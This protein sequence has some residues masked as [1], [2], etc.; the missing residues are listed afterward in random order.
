MCRLARSHE[1][2][3]RQRRGAG[4]GRDRQR[5][6]EGIGARNIAEDSFR[7]R[8]DHAQRDQKQDHA[9]GNRQRRFRDVHQD[10]KSVPTEHERKQHHIGDQAFAEDDPDAVRCRRRGERRSDQ[11]HV[12]ERVDDE[13]QQDRRGQEFCG[14]RGRRR[15]VGG[16]RSISPNPVRHGGRLA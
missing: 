11:R 13:D 3:R 16:R 4:D 5:H 2:D 9:A 8:K 14:H 15:L 7:V 12:A 6:D 10:E 1:H